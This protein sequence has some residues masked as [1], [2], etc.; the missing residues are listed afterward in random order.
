MCR[1]RSTMARGSLEQPWW[2]FCDIPQPP[3]AKMLKRTKRFLHWRMPS[4]KKIVILSWSPH[5]VHPLTMDYRLWKTLVLCTATMKS[6]KPKVK[7]WWQFLS[8]HRHNK[9]RLVL[10][11]HSWNRYLWL[12]GW[13]EMGCTLQQPMARKTALRIGVVI[14]IWVGQNGRRRGIKKER[15]GALRELSV[16]I[17]HNFDHPVPHSNEKASRLESECFLTQWRLRTMW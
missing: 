17:F 8:S 2:W 12:C 7:L 5:L 3:M 6:S 9:S 10:H 15:S 4:A 16:N 14:A 1:C 13:V 11:W